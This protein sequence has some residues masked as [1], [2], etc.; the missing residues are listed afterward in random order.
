MKNKIIFI[1]YVFFSITFTNIQNAKE[2]LIY[3]DD[4][5][6]DS[7]ENL[8]AKGNAKVISNNEIITSNLIVFKKDGSMVVT[9]TTN[10]T[11]VGR[12][13]IYVAVF[14]KHD[15]RKIYNMIY[16]DNISNKSYIKRFAVKGVTRDKQYLLVGSP[17]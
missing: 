17:K 15:E 16:R 4:I 6:Y 13:I 7:N 3:A 12:D 11:F 1:L 10:K 8:I 2:L 5:S 14:K 9:K